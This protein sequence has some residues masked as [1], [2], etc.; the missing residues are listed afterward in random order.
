[1]KRIKIDWTWVLA[2]VLF[3]LVILFGVWYVMMWTALTIT[4]EGIR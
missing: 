1:M 2:H 3:G 4:M